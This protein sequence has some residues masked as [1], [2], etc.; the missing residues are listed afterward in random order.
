MRRAL[1]WLAALLSLPILYVLAGFGGALIPAGG[2]AADGPPAMTVG[3]ISGPIHYD[4]LLPLTPETRETFGFLADGGVFVGDPRAEWLIIGWGARDFYTT[5]G[6]YTDVSLRATAKGVF[7]D[8]SVL[9]ASTFGAID[10]TQGID[11]L[12]LTT[13]QYTRLLAAIRGSFAPDAGVL[14]AYDGQS[15]FYHAAGR[16]NIWRTCNVWVG[17]MLRATGL[18]FGVWTPTPQAVRLSLRRFGHLSP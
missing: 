5:V 1:R 11:S 18:R 8:T 6:T 12:A 10:V 16:F 14:R 9:R 15:A 3:L 7:G 13:D 17:D 2:G 4:F